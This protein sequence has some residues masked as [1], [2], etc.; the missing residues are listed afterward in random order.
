MKE[1]HM[2]LPKLYSPK[3]SDEKFAKVFLLQKVT[4]CGIPFT[5]YSDYM[6]YKNSYI[7]K[8]AIITLSL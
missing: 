1:A 4:L 7:N 6:I 5:F 3:V 2:N 8:V